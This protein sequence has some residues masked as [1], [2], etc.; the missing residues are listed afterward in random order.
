MQIGVDEAGRG[1]LAG[2]VFAAAVI[3]KDPPP[4]HI[5]IKDSKKMTLNQR[6]A[7][8]EYIEENAVAWGVASIDATTID[9]INI[10][11]ATYKAMHKAIDNLLE[12]NSNLSIERII[13]DG[14]R[15]KTYI[16]PITDEFIP[17]TCIV[18]GDDSV[19]SVAAASIL[20][21]TYRDE[22]VINEMHTQFPMYDWKNNKAYGTAKHLQ[23]VQTHGPCHLHRF[24]FHPITSAQ[25]HTRDP[26][27]DAHDDQNRQD[28]H[29]HHLSETEYENQ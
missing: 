4:S 17:H 13:V 27:Y 25:T 9:K 2:P 29:N 5:V 1:C 6:N 21:K 8:R 11:N 7:A 10:L 15:F 19:M 26:R 18:K 23:A 16:S 22:Y 14:N 28:T 3:I 24:S 12:K 20:A